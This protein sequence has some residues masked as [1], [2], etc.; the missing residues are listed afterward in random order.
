M[1][2]TGSNQT[3]VPPSQPAQ[4]QSGH[5]CGT[6]IEQMT[7]IAGMRHRKDDSLN[8]NCQSK[9]DLRSH[10]AIAVRAEKEGLSRVW[11]ERAAF[12]PSW[13]APIS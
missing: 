12:I 10:V 8:D 2:H 3:G 1:R 9:A 4:N 11:L 5:E 13:D 6:E 7:R